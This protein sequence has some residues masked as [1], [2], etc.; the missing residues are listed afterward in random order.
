M[1]KSSLI[2][3]L[4]L[5][6]T[7]AVW[8]ENVNINGTGVSI[9]ANKTPINTAK[10]SDAIAQL[11]KDYRFA[12]PGKFT[13]AVAD[14]L[15]LEL[16]VVPTSWEDWPLGV[17]SGKYDAAISNIT[18]TKARKEKFD[19]ATYRKD[20]LGFYVKSTSPINSLV[21]AEDIAGLRIIVGSGTNQEAILLAWNEENLKKGL[22]PFTP[23]YTKDDAAQTLALQS[24]RAD[25]Y[26]GPNVIGA[27]K[28][29]LNGKTKL[30]GSVD[31]GWPKAAHIAVTLKKG[32]GL[33]EPV[34]T[35]LNGAIKN[36]D[37]DKVLNRWGEGVERIPSS[38]VNPACLGD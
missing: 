1:Q 14:S 26:F 21:K 31:G 12:V 33:V 13:V 3:A 11:P 24:G 6:F 17:A 25:A 35:A 30:V 2:L 15:G 4:A 23:I 32:S 19:F 22:K 16:N 37:Y 18:V 7:P 28:A 36:G 34:Q 9:E 5:A 8:A 29:A 20:S 38:E 27:W 10:N